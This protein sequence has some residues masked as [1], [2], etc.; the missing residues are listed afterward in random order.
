MELLVPPVPHAC[1]PSTA[2]P[3]LSLGY[4]EKGYTQKL[5]DGIHVYVAGK[6]I[7]NSPQGASAI[8]LIPDVWGW[9]GGRTRAIADLLVDSK[10][11][12]YVVVPK[13]LV[14]PLDGGTDGDGLPPGF[15]LRTRGSEFLA[16]IQG[17]FDWSTTLKPTMHS[18]MKF[19]KAQGA[20]RI[21]VLGY[22]FGAMVSTL[23]AAE[24]PSV[25]CM[26][27]SHPS[28]HFFQKAWGGPP[29]EA[30]AAKA[31]HVPTLVQPAGDDLPTYGPEGWVRWHTLNFLFPFNSRIEE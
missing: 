30:M 29:P 27:I 24:E 7:D 8:I 2:H 25:C 5:R 23:I 3:H 21:G 16:W 15:D 28:L 6:A 19:T 18:V 1:C 4:V 11:A 31:S 10:V 20:T 17:R 14:P 13:L 12:D 26:V 9:N 22:C